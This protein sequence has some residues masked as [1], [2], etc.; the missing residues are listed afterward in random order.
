MTDELE[1][2]DGKV[3]AVEKYKEASGG[4][5]GPLV[6]ELGEEKPCFSEEGA[7]ILKHHGSY[8]QD[9]RD[10]RTPRK[11]QGLGKDYRFMVRT[12]FPGGSITAEQYLICDNLATRY[13]QDDLRVTSRQDFQFH[14]VVKRTL[15]PLIHDLNHLAHVTTLGG[16]GD[17]VRN[18]MACPVVDIDP[19]YAR[20]G[21]D[22]IGLAGEIS[23]HFLPKT[24]S[25][26]DLWVNDE[27]VRANEDGTVVFLSE[28]PRESVEEPIYGKTYLPRKFKI[29]LAVDF[30]NSVDVYTQDIGVI[31]A[32]EEGRIVGFE[33]L[34]GGSLGYTHHKPQ[35]Y[36]RLASPLAFVS[37][38]ELIPLLEAIVKVQRDHGGRRDRRRARLKYLI[39]DWGFE[40]FR[41]SVFEYAGRSYPSPRGIE[42]TDQP[43]YLGWHKQTQAG[44][45]YVGVWV[46]NGRIRDFSGSFQFK[47]GLPTIIERYRPSVRLTPHHNI[48]LANI[49]DEDVEAVQAL[50]KQYR[51]PTDEGISGI[52]RHEMACPALPFCGLALAEAERYMPKVMQYLEENGYAQEDVVIRMSGCP[53][54]C[55][56]P[57]TAELGIVGCGADRYQICVGGGRLG[58]R[59]NEVLF[60]K[61]KGAELG[62]RI[63]LLLD[64]WK[65]DSLDG[66]GFGEWSAR[67]GLETLRQRIQTQAVV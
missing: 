38:A 50:L 45:H 66:E 33:V 4:L 17:V 37:Q 58:S 39:D 29:G 64:A 40:K 23:Q 2:G 6:T 12:K 1:G 55:S 35:T 18:T 43:D 60:D 14:G 25:Y 52:R 61:V 56:R 32:T 67:V 27:K 49:K 54:N 21:I 22:L 28:R 57:R 31:A 5:Y 9:D 41:E 51:I 10:T 34:V 53:N 30:D 36:A 42:P 47:T 48:I 20:C 63:A 24:S 8:Q 13:G 11:K 62:P 3:S 19:K 16:C 46:E 59:L 65:A 15:R 26:Y 44:L 7:H